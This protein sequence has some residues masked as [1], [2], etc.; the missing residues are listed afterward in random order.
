MLNFRL[1]PNPTPSQAL[2]EACA[3]SG[4]VD[5]I[6]YP[7]LAQ[8][9]GLDVVAVFEAALAPGALS[10]HDPASGLQDQLP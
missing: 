10:V 6:L 4:C 7:S 5:G 2:G 3:R 9:G 8:T 1:R